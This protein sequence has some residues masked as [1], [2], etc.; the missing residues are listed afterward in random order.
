MGEIRWSRPLPFGP[1]FAWGAATS[2]YQIEGAAHEDGRGESIWDRFATL[3]GSVADESTGEVAADHYHRWPEDIGLMREL[4]LRAYRFSVAW[5]RVIPAGRGAVN[6]R[7]LAFYDRLVDGLLEAGIEPWV[8]LYHWD[9]PQALENAGGWPDRRTAHAFE[10]Y[11]DVVS[12]RLGDR[13]QRWI[14]INEPWEIGFLGHL[15]GEHAPGVRDLRTALAAIH[16]VLM[17]HGRAATVI[18]SNVRDSSIGIALSPSACYPATATEANRAARSRMDG[19][20][21]RWF[22]DPILGKGYPL[23]TVELYGSAAPRIRAGDME[24][25][26]QPLDFLGLNYY[27][28]LWVADD[29]AA[30]PLRARRVQPPSEIPT[31]TMGWAVDP[32]GLYATLVGLQA[33]SHEVPIVI[34][35]S[36]AAFEDRPSSDGAIPDADRLLYH[37]AYLDAAARAVDD[38]VRLV[39]YFAWSLLDNF[40]WAFGYGRRFGLVYVDFVTQRRT[41]KRS[42]R[43]YRQVIDKGHLVDPSLVP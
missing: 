9:L 20:M 32:D 38:G 3:P 40:E 36:G 41:V 8:T 34:T 21:N 27:F 28:S 17:A 39:G 25:I 5:P 19:S 13:V 7:G 30:P 1:E 11:T 31:T 14:T 4:G 33:M 43:W 42:G 22:L 37:A 29:P 35:E 23:D 10:Q 15:T 2:A 26:A 24:M 6:E 18:R 16:T 12:R